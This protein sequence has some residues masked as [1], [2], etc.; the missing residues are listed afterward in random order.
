MDETP[1]WARRL[2]EVEVA[3]LYSLYMC[4]SDI[5]VEDIIELAIKRGMEI[6]REGNE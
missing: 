3:T 5:D 4:E 6:E 1:Y 2:V